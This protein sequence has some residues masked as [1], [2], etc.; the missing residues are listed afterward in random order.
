MWLSTAMWSSSLIQD[1]S[2]QMLIPAVNAVGFQPADLMRLH[3]TILFPEH[4]HTLTRI[5]RSFD[6]CGDEHR[7]LIAD[8]A[9]LSVSRISA[10]LHV[11][12]ERQQLCDVWTGGDLWVTTGRVTRAKSNSAVVGASS[13]RVSLWPLPRMSLAPIQTLW[14]RQPDAFTM[15]IT[16]QQLCH[17]KLTIFHSVTTAL[18]ERRFSQWLRRQLSAIVWLIITCLRR[19]Q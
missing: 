19:E 6:A 7:R 9:S 4:R 17:R 12:S 15:F 13:R 2:P 18:F 16:R 11:G 8:I 5:H 14:C 10:Q 3:V 1:W